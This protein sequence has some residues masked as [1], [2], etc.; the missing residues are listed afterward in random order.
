[1]RDYLIIAIV[2]AALPVGVVSPYYGLLVYSW[3]SYMN[4]HMLAWT[5]AQ[6]FPVGKLSAASALVGVVLRHEWDLAP[7]K[8]L[9]NL[10]MVL[11]LFTFCMS[12]LFA[13]YP[14]EAWSKL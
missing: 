11:L 9:E 13:V 1:M 14:E 2:L 5:F 8:E 6:T 3:I 7:L 4:P 12:T 10:L